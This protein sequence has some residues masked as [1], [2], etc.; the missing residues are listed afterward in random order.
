MS[1]QRYES[2][3]LVVLSEA[4]AM[5]SKALGITFDEKTFRPD[6]LAQLLINAALE[7]PRLNAAALTGRAVAAFQ[8][9]T[10]H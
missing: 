4:L 10:M 3:S 6:L 8:K 9:S 7:N 2:D 5:A 1:F